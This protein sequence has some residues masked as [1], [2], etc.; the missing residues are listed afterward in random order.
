MSYYTRPSDFIEIS[1]AAHTTSEGGDWIPDNEFCR[2]R[3]S[4]YEPVIQ[5]KKYLKDNNIHAIKTRDG[6]IFDVVNCWRKEESTQTVPLE[7][8]S[9]S[10]EVERTQEQ[11]N[12]LA[13]KLIDAWCIANDSRISWKGACKICFIVGSITQEQYDELVKMQ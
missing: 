11:K 3:I 8:N 5:L 6:R 1:I 9:Q 4:K 7:V 12:V 10:A 2:L 13:S